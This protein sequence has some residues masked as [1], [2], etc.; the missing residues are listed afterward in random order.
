VKYLLLV[1]AMFPGCTIS[2]LKVDYP[3]PKPSPTPPML[4]YYEPNIPLYQEPK[5]E[6]VQPRTPSDDPISMCFK[7]RCTEL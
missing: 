5:N 6:K 1:V 4:F 2:F 3:E 7:Q